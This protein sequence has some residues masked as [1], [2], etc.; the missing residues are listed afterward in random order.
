[1]SA[2]LQA[3]MSV[4][5]FLDWEQRQPTKYEFDGVHPV[6]MTGV[7]LE[8]STIQGNIMR[9]A[10]SRLRGGPCRI[11]GSDFKVLVAGSIRYPDALVVCSPQHPGGYVATEPV[12]I[13]EIASPTT[14]SVDRIDKNEEYRQTPS[15]KRY[16]LLEQDKIAA[17]V[18][19][20]DGDRWV[21]ELLIGDRLL[22]MP[23]IGVSIPL[24][25]LYE[26]VTLQPP[27]AASSVER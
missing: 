14:A 16:V 11:H 9:A 17:T 12:V 5:D 20:R 2:A 24:T 13:F 19:S 23:E 25:E 4:A 27:D 15:V 3:P 18:F 21:G 26:D 8:H 10:G 22:A 1:M 6:A 7:S